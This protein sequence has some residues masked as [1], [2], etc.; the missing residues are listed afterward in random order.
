[1]VNK[2]VKQKCSRAELAR[3]RNGL[4]QVGWGKPRRAGS[5]QKRKPLFGEKKRNR[6]F[7]GDYWQLGEKGGGVKAKSGYRCRQRMSAAGC[8]LLVVKS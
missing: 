3:S 7:V 4:V 5:G 8:G 6:G 1:M 2:E